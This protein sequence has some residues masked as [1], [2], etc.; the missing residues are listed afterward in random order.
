MKIAT[1]IFIL[2]ICCSCSTETA[3]QKARFQYFVTKGER[4]LWPLILTGIRAGNSQERDKVRSFI[5]EMVIL[6]GCAS[7]HRDGVTSDLRTDDG[8]QIDVDLVPNHDVHP[9]GPHGTWC[10][11]VKG[12]FQ[13]VDFEKR[14]IHITAKPKDYHVMVVY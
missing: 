9:P 8:I 3:W 11:E 2:L 7:L 1:F 6:E 14:V 4:D 10:A 12:I 5:G 13:S